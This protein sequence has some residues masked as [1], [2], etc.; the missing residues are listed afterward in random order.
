[1]K[2]KWIFSLL[3]A[4]FLL[5]LILPVANAL[6]ETVGG[7][8]SETESDSMVIK[9][10]AYILATTWN[11]RTTADLSKPSVGKFE[12]DDKVE[13]VRSFT[14]DNE[15]WLEIIF[16]G[17]RGHYIAN[18]ANSVEVVPETTYVEKSKPPPPP[19]EP[20]FIQKL[21]NNKLVQICGGAVVVIFILIYAFIKLG[22]GE[23]KKLSE[24]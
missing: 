6:V 5:V 19:H 21:I 17:K 24:R 16:N 11:I 3:I 1:M 14:K 9:D 22:G 23:R 13:I 2:V 7:P 15:K 20:G 8:A 18:R 12:K 10:Y 4:I